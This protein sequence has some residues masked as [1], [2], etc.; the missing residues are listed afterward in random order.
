MDNQIKQAVQAVQDAICFLERYPDTTRH[1]LVEDSV[2]TN[3]LQR[4][5]AGTA[6]TA[7][8]QA[9][10]SDPR[11][12]YDLLLPLVEAAYCLGYQR[13]RE[14]REWPEFVVGEEE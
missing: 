10:Y 3:D 6:Y 4:A 1:P 9:A 13:G 8:Q 7:L 14:H 11:R 5:V 12:I 2:D